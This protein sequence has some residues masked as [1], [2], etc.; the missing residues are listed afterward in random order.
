M[1]YIKCTDHNGY[2][3]TRILDAKSRV[4]PVRT[5]SIPRLELCS[6][7]LLS[8]LVSSILSAL[9]V[10]PKNIFLWS[11]STVT[12]AWISACP[13]RSKQFVANRVSE[14]QKLTSNAQWN[15][16][17][18]EDNPADLIL[19]GVQPSRLI[20]ASLWWS[21]PTWL[22]FSNDQWPVSI[23]APTS[24]T[25]L[26]ERVIK[27]QAFVT[28]SIQ[29]QNHSSWSKLIRTTAYVFRFIRNTQARSQCREKLIGHLTTEEFR[30][31]TLHCCKLVQAEEFS[32]DITK[33]SNNKNLSSKS[34]LL[35][36][37]PFIDQEGVL[38][39][40]GRLRHSSFTNDKKHPIL[41][42]KQHHIT[43][44]IAK[45][46]HVTNLHVGPQTL[47][48]IIRQKYWPLSG[49]NL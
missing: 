3:Q 43:K 24:E 32:S 37:A 38:R 4:A 31:A 25:V 15:H 41:L 46:L 20:E 16:I 11:D 12:L 18:S 42:P 36:L 13:S 8:Q 29:F 28:S 47:L 19:R 49:K 26:E 1:A 48:T 10:K 30:Q 17:K 39:V 9:K 33:P 5:L 2:N 14:I 21:G 22:R 44:L 27:T 40:G 7:L 23:T 6:A 35:C 45:Y 34:K